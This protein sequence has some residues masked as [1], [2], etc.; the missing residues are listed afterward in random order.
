[1]LTGRR[2]RCPRGC[3]RGAAS[4]EGDRRTRPSTTRAISGEEGGRPEL[5]DSALVPSDH[6]PHASPDAHVSGAPPR[7]HWRPRA[8]SS[9]SDR[10]T[11]LTSARSNHDA[12]RRETTTGSLM[13]R[14][15]TAIVAWSWMKKASAAS[16]SDAWACTNPSTGRAS[17]LDSSAQRAPDVACDSTRR[18]EGVCGRLGWPL[19]LT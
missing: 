1:M 14:L 15:L 4:F 19:R 10:W 16:L 2:R 13:L 3:G 5:R 17:R 8:S 18:L 9:R 6:F 12:S 7:L 11:V